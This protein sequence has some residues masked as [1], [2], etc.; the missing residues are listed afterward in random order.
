MASFQGLAIP[1]LK[2]EEIKNTK[3][4]ELC[5]KTRKI[6]LKFGV[7]RDV[8]LLNYLINL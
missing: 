8:G 3:D 6:Q 5:Y 4:R 1:N 2:I 7:V